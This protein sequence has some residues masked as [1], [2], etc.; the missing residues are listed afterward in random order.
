MESR[1]TPKL[2]RAISG[3]QNSMSCDVFY[4]IEKI[5]ERRCLKWVRIV[6]LD[7]W[8]TSYGPKKGRE[9][10]WQFDSQP[11][12]SQESTQFTCL[13]MACN[14]PLESSWR[15][16]QRCFTLH[17]DPRSARKVM[18]LQNCRSPNLGD[19]GT[20][21]W[22]SWNKKTIWMWAAWRGEEYTIKGKVVASPKSGL[23]WVL[24]VRVAHGSS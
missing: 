13:K 12:K 24:C 20:P 5:L 19:F 2:Q 22:E 15:G 1:W 6:H 8:N 17:L 3:G 11:E 10:N 21:T 23:W 9:S 4:I 14:I 18:G 7:I 16:L